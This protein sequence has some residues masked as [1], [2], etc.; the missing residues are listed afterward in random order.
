MGPVKTFLNLQ[1]SILTSLPPLQASAPLPNNKWLL[2]TVLLVMT[3]KNKQ[4]SINNNLPRK[5]EPLNKTD[6]K[7]SC[8]KWHL[9]GLERDGKWLLFESKKKKKEEWMIQ[10]LTQAMK[11]WLLRHAWCFPCRGVML[12]ADYS[13]LHSLKNKNPPPNTQLSG[14]KQQSSPC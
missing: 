8:G 1:M 10:S 9:R 7:L 14:L 6:T 13:I 5:N 2:L 11:V 3:A 4:K 12:F